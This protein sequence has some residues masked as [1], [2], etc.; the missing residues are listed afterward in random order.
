M[1]KKGELS[2]YDYIHF[3]THGLVN[4]QYP[5]LSGLLL[6]QNKASVEDGI[7][8]TGEIYGLDLKA[9]LVTL[10]ACETAL[11]KR[12]E[13]EG[14]RGLTTSFLFAG[15]RTV[16]VSLWKVADE[17]TS[18]LM[19]NFYNELLTGKDKSTALR[20]AKLSLLKDANYANPFYWSPFVQIGGN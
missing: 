19:I 12:V 6:A 14:L 15:A 1:V 7:L 10:S 16:V 8:Y 18:Q 3:A 20:D 4:S 5:E 11:G 9:D 13:G 2:K 17:S